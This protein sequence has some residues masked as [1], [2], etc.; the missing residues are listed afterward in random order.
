MRYR[1]VVFLLL[2]AGVGLAAYFAAG[3]LGIW[4]APGQAQ[5]RPVPPGDQEIAWIAPATSGDAWERLVAALKLLQ[6]DWPK[7]HGGA[8]LDLDLDLDKA[9]L[10][11]TA[12]VPEIGLQIGRAHV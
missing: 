3:T 11:L 8:A 5:V 10:D 9:F 1:W 12:E 4:N 7:L 2:F 6:Q